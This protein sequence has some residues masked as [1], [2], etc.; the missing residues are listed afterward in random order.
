MLPPIFSR[1]GIFGWNLGPSH[2]RAALRSRTWSL[3]RELGCLVEILGRRISASAQSRAPVRPQSSAASSVIWWCQVSSEVKPG[4]QSGRLRVDDGFPV[5]DEDF[6]TT[7][8]GLYIVGQPFHS[9]LWSLLWFRS[10]VHCIGPHCRC[11]PA[12]VHSLN[13]CALKRSR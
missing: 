4:V 7:L 8:P 6:Q 10:R 13:S 12:A 1:L 11:K 5:R 9:V 2:F 3:H